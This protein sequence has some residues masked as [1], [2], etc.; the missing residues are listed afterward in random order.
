MTSEKQK[1]TSKILNVEDDY[2][3]NDYDYES[4]ESDYEYEQSLKNKND[5]IEKLSITIQNILIKYVSCDNNYY[6]NN[7]PLPLCEFLTSK[8]ILNYINNLE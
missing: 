2:N 5:T 1:K 4:N 3:N 7:I 6:G 8:K